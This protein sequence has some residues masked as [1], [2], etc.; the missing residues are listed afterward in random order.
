MTM[1][2]IHPLTET[3]TMNLPG[4]KRQPAL[5]ADKP[6]RHLLADCLENVRALWASTV[7]YRIAL[8][9]FLPFYNFT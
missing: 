3:S 6:H 5:K 7:C 9:V 2:W 8:P 4:G 1:A